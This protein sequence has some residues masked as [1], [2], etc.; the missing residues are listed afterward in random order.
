MR[1]AVK[2]MPANARYLNQLA[3]LLA[4]CADD[5]YRD[6]PAALAIAEQACDLSGETD[7][8]ILDTRAVAHAEC[9]DFAGAVRWAE[10]ALAVATPDAKDELRERLKLFRSGKTYRCRGA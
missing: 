4:T 5:Q 7:A 2:L 1:A 8:L 9:G 3:W 6:A 10:A